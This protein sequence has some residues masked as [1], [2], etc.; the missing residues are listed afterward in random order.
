MLRDET[1]IEEVD[2]KKQ[3]EAATLKSAQ[4]ALASVVQTK[5]IATDT[6][7]TLHAQGEQMDNMQKNVDAIL[8]GQKVAEKHT[9]S[10]GSIF[11]AIFNALFRKKEDY[12]PPAPIVT[13][14]STT[15]PPARPTIILDDASDD[16]PNTATILTQLSGHLDDV[17]EMAQ[18]MS[19]ELSKHN[20]KLEK[21]A[22]TV[23][24]ANVNMQHLNHRIS[25]LN[26]K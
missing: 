7:Q 4:N 16:E 12:V 10:I 24:Q 14:P 25:A 19:T 13:K 8:E 9:D 26:R 11:G 17:Q 15:E 6:L 1:P 20:Q 3:L 23:H 2:I 22:P 5:Q 18:Q 21:M